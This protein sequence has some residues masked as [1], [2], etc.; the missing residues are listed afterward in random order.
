[1]LVAVLCAAMLH[2]CSNSMLTSTVWINQACAKRFQMLQADVH[3]HV[4]SVTQNLLIATSK[5]LWSCG[6]HRDCVR[7]RFKAQRHAPQSSRTR[8]LSIFRSELGQLINGLLQGPRI[9]VVVI[10]DTFP[11][12]LHAIACGGCR[13]SICSSFCAAA[14]TFVPHAVLG[15]CCCRATNRMQ[16]AVTSNHFFLL[17]A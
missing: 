9:V 13:C 16:S 15:V 5:K 14:P 3:S 17:R 4:L 2:K 6:S 8:V 7:C 11:A 1:M 12:M 10:S